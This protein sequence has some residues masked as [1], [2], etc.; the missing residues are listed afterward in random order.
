MGS[1]PG[2]ESQVSLRKWA[3]LGLMGVCAGLLVT[4]MNPWV[5]YILELI[6][7]IGALTQL[8]HV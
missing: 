2:K 3:A 8:A 5:R 4:P 1:S 6:S 7:A